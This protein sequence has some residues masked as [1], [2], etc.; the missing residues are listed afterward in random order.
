MKEKIK[1]RRKRGE[2]KH[3]G[4]GMKMGRK[5]LQKKWRATKTE[6]QTMERKNL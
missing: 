6:N 5:I 1:F 4:K 3:S 2:K